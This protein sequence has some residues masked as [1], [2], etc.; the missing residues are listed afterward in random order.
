MFHHTGIVLESAR[1]R[2]S[3][4]A[5]PYRAS[6]FTDTRKLYDELLADTSKYDNSSPLSAKRVPP[7]LTPFT[8]RRPPLSPSLNVASSFL[9]CLPSLPKGIPS[10]F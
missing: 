1:R 9:P 6:V 10:D 8:S 2:A 5:S 3:L 4:D 7:D